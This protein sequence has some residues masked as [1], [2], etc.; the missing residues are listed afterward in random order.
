[1]SRVAKAPIEIPAGIEVSL[2]DSLMTVKGK[3]GQMQ[4]NFHPLVTVTNTDNVLTFAITKVDKKDEKKAWAQAGTV[5]A[6]TANLIQGVSEGWIK[7]LTLIGVGY[8]AKSMGKV[9]DLTLGFSHPVQYA[10]PEGITAETPSQTEIVVKGM[11]KQK[12]GQV[13]AEIRAFRP[14]EPYKGKGV[15]YTDEYVVRKEAKK[16]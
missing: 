1:M 7:K 2:K 4:M 16:K 15:R 12:V 3:L 9:L 6:N 13:A 14:P 11:D 5:R 8:R 10:L